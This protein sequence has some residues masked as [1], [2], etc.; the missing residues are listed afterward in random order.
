MKER[1]KKKRKK[2]KER[3]IPFI[4]LLPQVTAETLVTLRGLLR[5]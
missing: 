5:A 3:H 1:K 4:E 2:E